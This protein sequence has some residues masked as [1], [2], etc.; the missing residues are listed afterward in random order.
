MCILF[1][2]CALTYQM[3]KGS[4]ADMDMDA[5]DMSQFV[6]CGFKMGAVALQGLEFRQGR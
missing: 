1:C 6:S 2:D 3:P 5:K 4:H